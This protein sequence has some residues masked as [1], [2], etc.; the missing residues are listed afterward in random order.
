MFVLN[1]LSSQEQVEFDDR[2]QKQHLP[3]LASG[4]ELF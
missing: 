2:G 3:W 4:A 1:Y